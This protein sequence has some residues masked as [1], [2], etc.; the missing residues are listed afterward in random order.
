MKRKLLILI[1][2]VI[3]AVLITRHRSVDPQPVADT[4]AVESTQTHCYERSVLA[5]ETEPYTV[6]QHIT[7]TIDGTSVTGTKSGTQAG[8]DMTNGY[9][10]TL[11][12]TVSDP[13]TLLYTYTIEGSTQQEQEQYTVHGNYL[14][15]HR[16]PLLEQN[17]VLIPDITKPSTDQTY[18]QIPC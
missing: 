8:P 2:I 1:P 3:A 12:G 6:H 4:Q 5:T 11:Q 18:K 13:L 15:K 17:G 9:E 10:G 14:I 16:Y 7:L